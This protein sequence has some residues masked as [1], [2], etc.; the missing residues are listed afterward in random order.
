[1]GDLG[2]RAVRARR[3]PRRK[4][5][6]K[7]PPDPGFALTNNNRNPQVFIIYRSA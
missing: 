6:N 4:K 5:R 2:V 1:M 3:V 7:T